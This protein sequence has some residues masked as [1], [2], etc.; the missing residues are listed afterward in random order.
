MHFSHLSD[1]LTFVHKPYD[2]RPLYTPCDVPRQSGGSIQI[3]CLKGDEP[4]SVENKAFDTVAIEPEDLEPRRIELDRNLGTDPYQRQER[5]MRN[6]VTEDMDEFRITD[7]D[8]EDG[9]VRKML[10][11]PLFLQ[12]REDCESSRTP[13]APGKPAALLQERGASGKR[14]PVD[15]SKS[16]MSSSSQEEAKNP[17]TNSRV[18]FS[19]TLI[20]Q[21]WEDLFLNGT[22]IICLVRQDLKL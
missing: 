18:L 9:E 3:P 2:S 12:N 19:K 6:F 15:S 13:I 21:I 1:G 8:L 20:R 22:K 17:K 5:F 16:L 10:A 14:A 11:S 7:S 4:K